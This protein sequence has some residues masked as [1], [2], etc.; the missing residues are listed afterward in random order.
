MSVQLRLGDMDLIIEVEEDFTSYGDECK[1]GGGK[2]RC[3]LFICV[4]QSRLSK[5]MALYSSIYFI[6][7]ISFSK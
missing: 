3:L 5:I 6:L 4:T 7:L 1:F 2:V